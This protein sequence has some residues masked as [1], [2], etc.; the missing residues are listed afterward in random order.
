MLSSVRNFFLALIISLAL[1]GVTAYFLI[2]FVDDSARGFGTQ[3]TTEAPD[4][5]GQSDNGDGTDEPLDTSEFTALIIG[6]D[7]GASQRSEK[8]EADAIFLV[9]INAKTQ[10]LMISPLSR[11]MKIDVKGYT[12][13]LGAVYSEFDVE[14]L[15]RV[16]RSYTGLQADYYCV[17][18]YES[19]EIIFEALG[20]VEFDVPMDMFYDPFMH[21]DEPTTDEDY[22][23]TTATTRNPSDEE[24]EEETTK[25]YERISLASGTQEINGEM[26]V[27]IMRYGKY[28]SR[29]IPEKKKTVMTFNEASGNADRM[30]TQ[31]DFI[32]EVLKQKLTFENLINA[33]EIYEEVKEGVVETNMDARDF[34]NYAETI[35]SLADYT[36]RDVVYPGIPRLENGVPFFAPDVKSAVIRYR[37]YRKELIEE[38]E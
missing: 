26:A 33:R 2:G 31:T 29:T 27:Q 19:I 25:D 3:P 30:K 10:V 35:F 16:I 24:E 18:D 13:R 9:N 7:S 4:S 36:I 15:I 20:D 23:E 6:I 14:T 17:L 32:K 1:F 8:Q 5:G 38:A 37:P 34:E 11:D 22:V 21:T 12:L 28:D